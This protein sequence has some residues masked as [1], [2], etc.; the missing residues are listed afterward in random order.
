M[1]VFE[2]LP[3]LIAFAFWPAVIYYFYQRSK[4]NDILKRFKSNKPKEEKIKK[5]KK[6][7]RLDMT[8][9]DGL[10][11]IQKKQDCQIILYENRINIVVTK[12]MQFNIKNESIK[13]MNMLLAKDLLDKNKSSVLRGAI[14]S[15]IAGPGGLILG[16]MSGIKTGKKSV[17]VLII[18]YISK[19]SEEKS[20]VFAP[21]F[22]KIL[23]ENFIKKFE[24]LSG[25]SMK[26][27]TEL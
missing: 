10:D 26:V 14:G 22:N 19:N 12:D 27:N 2:I 1:I 11:N 6:Y 17:Y 20:L 15:V 13:S 23:T 3:Y 4:G 21:K 9:I 25:Q 24:K 18:N 5:E 8:H 16:G 7:D